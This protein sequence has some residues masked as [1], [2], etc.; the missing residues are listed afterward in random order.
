MRPSR[1][2]S[3]DTAF[4]KKKVGRPFDDE[5][6]RAYEQGLLDFIAKRALQG[7]EAVFGRV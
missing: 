5:G 4:R 7:K 1:S 3:L 6:I 2:N